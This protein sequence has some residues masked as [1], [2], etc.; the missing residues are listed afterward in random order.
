MSDQ[1]HDFDQ[2]LISGY[3]D[4]ELTQADR[5][6][7]RLHIESCGECKSTADELRQLSEITMAT[8]FQKPDDTQWDESPRNAVSRWLSLAGW[9]LAA[10]W[11]VTLVGYLFWQWR[12][13]GDATWRYEWFVAV[14]YLPAFGLILASTL[15][16]RLQTR[17]TDNYRK[18]KK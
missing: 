7:V 8:D 1:H 15:V 6:R 18:V 9:A 5:Q 16:D 12:N 13:D 3:L 2:S 10:I 17:K 14:G 11:A 4:G